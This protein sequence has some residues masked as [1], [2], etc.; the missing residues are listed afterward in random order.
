MRVLVV[1]LGDIARKA[2]LPV[3]AAM[4][5]LELHLATRNRAVLDDVGAMYRI[6][7]RYTGL[8]AALAAGRY[9]AAFVHAATLAHPALVEALLARDIPILVDKPLADNLDEAARLIDCAT[10]RGLLLTVGFNRRFAPDYAALRM[11]PRSLVTMHK[12]RRAHPDTPR[13]VIFDDF[14]HVADTLRFLAPARIDREQIDVI[15]RDGLLESVMLTLAGEGFHAV[16]TM[17]RRS[18][19]DEEQLDIVGGDAR[20][21][22]LNLS[23]RVEADGAVCV[24]R[25]GDWIPVAR[26]RGFEAMC[27]DFLAGVREGGATAAADLYDTHALCERIVSFAVPARAA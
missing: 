14:I 10:R 7:H 4:P 26:Q 3:L 21:A 24:M 1:G 11:V 6:T 5:E 22:V 12:H 2:Y 18:G 8:E 20:R 25:R 19:L 23:E 17:N 27:A 9:D 13:R 16:G 15:V